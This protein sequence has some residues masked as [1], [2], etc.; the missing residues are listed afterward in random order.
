MRWKETLL[1]S[2]LER[3]KK[4]KGRKGKKCFSGY[5]ALNYF[6]HGHIWPY[7]CQGFSAHDQVLLSGPR[8]AAKNSKA[9]VSQFE[10]VL[11]GSGFSW[12][13]NGESKTGQMC[14]LLVYV[15]F[16]VQLG[17]SIK[18]FSCLKKNGCIGALWCGWDANVNQLMVVW[19]F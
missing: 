12:E 2:P 18:P 17:Q 7:I 5:Y 19:T 3:L 4:R 13:N 10:F 6:T 8:K 1:N 9:V 16:I 15:L 14:Q 11:Q